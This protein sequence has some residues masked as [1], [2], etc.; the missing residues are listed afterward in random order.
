M[1][2]PVDRALCEASLTPFW[3]DDAQRPQAERALTADVTADLVIVGGGFTGLCAAVQAKEAHPEK[4]IVLLEAREIAAGASGRPGGIISTS[5]M[6]G[7]R[8]EASVFPDDVEAIERLGKENLDGFRAA[9]ERFG[10]DADIEWNGEMTVAV[11]A[12]GLEKI[13]DEYEPHQSH[14]HDV[15]LLDREETQNELRSPVFEGAMW[16]RQRSGIVHP[17]KLAWGLKAAAIGLGVRVFEHSPME[18]VEDHGDALV[19]VTPGG[20]VAA[21]RVLFATNAWTAGHRKIKR[22]VMAMRDRVLATAPLTDEQLGRLGWKNRQGVYDTRAQLNYMRLTR[23]NRIV[24]GRSV[25]YYF[26]GDINPAVDQERESFRDLVSSF[27]EKFP[28]LSDLGITHLWGGSIDYCSRFSVFF[29]RLFGEKAVYVGSTQAS[30]SLGA[31]LARASASLFSMVRIFRSSSWKSSPA[32][33]TS[34][35][36]DPF[37]GSGRG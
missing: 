34:F 31:D 13:R 11:S 25:R 26:N 15:E 19:I 21:N 30:V 29:E 2:S 17:A 14:G 20:R 10:I 7:L 22:R 4:S 8:N 5:V 36:P 32:G 3:L 9:V 23:D 18:A 12:D 33:P 24:F 37:A 35:R 28:Q 6:H 27:Y 16:S 1:S